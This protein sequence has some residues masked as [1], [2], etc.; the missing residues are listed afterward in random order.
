[1]FL[2]QFRSHHSTAS[3]TAKYPWLPISPILRRFISSSFSFECAISLAQEYR[4]RPLLNWLIH[5]HFFFSSAVSP[6]TKTLFSSLPFP[7]EYQNSLPDGN[8]QSCHIIVASD[9]CQFM[10]TKNTLDIV[11]G[12]SWCEV[13]WWPDRILLLL[14]VCEWNKDGWANSFLDSLLVK[15]HKRAKLLMPHSCATQSSF[16]S[17]WHCEN[18]SDQHYAGGVIHCF[19]VAAESRSQS[20]F[21]IRYFPIIDKWYMSTAHNSNPHKLSKWAK[22]N[23]GPWHTFLSCCCKL[24]FV[25]STKM[26][27]AEML[28]GLPEMEHPVWMYDVAVVVAAA[29]RMCT[30]R[31]RLDGMLQVGNSCESTKRQYKY[32]DDVKGRQGRMSFGMDALPKTDREK[33]KHNA[34]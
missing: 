12:V 34:K 28:C 17:C 23:E 29:E 30:F 15:C 33:Y 13:K 1:M 9:E 18:I 8:R 24:I 3:S 25:Y 20:T 26:L 10:F 2:C 14:A 4:L 5:F 21:R 7:F 11:Q 19:S 6:T 22:E 31:N 16:Y 32:Q 27:P